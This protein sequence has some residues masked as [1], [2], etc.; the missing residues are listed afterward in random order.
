MAT[1]RFDM[2]LLDDSQIEQAHVMNENLIQLIH[3]GRATVQSADTDAEPASPDAGDC[4]VIPNN[5]TG[6]VW[7]TL[8]E[9]DVVCWLHGKWRVKAPQR[10]MI[11]RVLDGDPAADRAEWRKYNTS[12]SDATL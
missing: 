9:G 7:S 2:T 11:I 3:F 12:W 5:A 8:D 10:G 1:A 4:F 6:T